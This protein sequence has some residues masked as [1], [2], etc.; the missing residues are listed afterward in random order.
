M[1]IGQPKDFVTQVCEVPVGEVFSSEK[2][3]TY[4]MKIPSTKIE[5]VT[6]P[7]NSVDLSTGHLFAFPPGTQVTVVK[8]AYLAFGGDK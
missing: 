2:L 7:V 4:Y 8:D 6:I 1:K 5:G 3:S